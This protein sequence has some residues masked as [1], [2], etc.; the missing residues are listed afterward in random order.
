MSNYKLPHTPA[1]IEKFLN[2]ISEILTDDGVSI[3][4]IVT[5]TANGHAANKSYVDSTA[6]NTLTTAKAYADDV[7]KAV[8]SVA[9]TMAYVVEDKRT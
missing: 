3:T 8:A 4:N 9:E 1:K 2:W 6:A 7:G 5:P